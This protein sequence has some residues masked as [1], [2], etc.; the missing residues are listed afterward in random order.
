[1]L[2]E[3]TAELAIALLL[4]T[5]RRLQE[6]MIAVKTGEWGSW[7]SEWL[8]G[9]DIYSSTIGTEFRQLFAT[10]TY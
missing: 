6:G 5:S 4:S 2:T 3:T 7:K 1:V 8:L 10:A 9:P